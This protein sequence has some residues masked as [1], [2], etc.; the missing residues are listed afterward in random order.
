VLESDT[1][2]IAERTRHIP[3]HVA[4]IVDRC[5]RKPPADRFA[6][7][8]EIVS[9][10]EASDAG[11]LRSRSAGHAATWWH[12]HQL[13]VMA[14]YVAA[15]TVAWS[16]KEASAASLSLWLFI[17]IGIGSAIGGILRG[18]LLFTSA[19]NRRHLTTERLRVR[20]PIMVV[21]M[22][23]ACALAIDGLSVATARPLWSMLTIAF[24]AGI[25]LA[26]ILIEPATAE[27]TFP[28]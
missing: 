3:A 9:A 20:R 8:S 6:S 11:L 12:V 28:E 21:D 15:T 27:A 14:V 25:A 7:A 18:H 16:I 26:T 19:V 5:L 10:L 17:A 1:R 13:V 4:A 2:P 23:M 22:L 24:A